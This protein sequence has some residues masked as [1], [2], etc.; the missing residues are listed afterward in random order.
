MKVIVKVNQSK[1][2]SESDRMKVQY[3][4]KRKEIEFGK[5]SKFLNILHLYIFEISFYD[6]KN[7]QHNTI[8][9][10][11]KTYIYTS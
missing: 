11:M 1:S 7:V 3:Q 6:H 8:I 10:S 2:E 4:N 5:K 9:V